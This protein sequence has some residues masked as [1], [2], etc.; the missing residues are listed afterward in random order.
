VNGFFSVI[1]SVL[2]TVLA[3]TV[4]FRAVQLGAFACYVLAGVALVRLYRTRRP[5][6]D[7]APSADD[8]VVAPLGAA[9]VGSVGSG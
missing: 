5:E 8:A 9:P 1:G 6:G 4:G 2:A 3:M 7:A